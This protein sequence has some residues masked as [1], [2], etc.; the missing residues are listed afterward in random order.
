ML[1][2]FWGKVKYIEGILGIEIFFCR[3]EG[4]NGRKM[5]KVVHDRHMYR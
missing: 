2:V 5:L 1:R 4:K 3:M